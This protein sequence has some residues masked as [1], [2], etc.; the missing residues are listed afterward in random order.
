MPE[1][2]LVSAVV[3]MT[4]QPADAALPHVEVL[5]FAELRRMNCAVTQRADFLV[6]AFVR[7]GTGAL[8][9]DFERH[10]LQAGAVAWIAPGSV[11][12]WD[13]IAGLDGVLLLV[14]PESPLTP[15]TRSAVTAARRP[16]VFIPLRDESRYLAAAVDHLALEVRPDAPGST[17]EVHAALLTA[18]LA[19]MPAGPPA[20]RVDGL[21]DRFRSAVDAGFRRHRDVRHYARELGYVERTL[22]RKVV[23]ATGRTAKAVIE[24]RVVL[25]A[26]RLL[27]HHRLSAAECSADLGF[28]DP[29]AFSVFFRRV[30]GLR[31]GAWLATQPSVSV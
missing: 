30:T 22:T 14:S 6:I 7:V 12:R 21:V 17:P 9:I 20:G 16:G 18:L 4:Y 13:D 19:R 5:D 11:H 10:T 28:S 3:Q 1:T 29:S 31:P 26:K 24:E 15:A 27:V 2:G 23:A 8:T 25:E